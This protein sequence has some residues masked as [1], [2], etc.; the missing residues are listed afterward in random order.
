M[1]GLHGSS[2][3]LSRLASP[4]VLAIFAASLAIGLEFSGGDA[5][6]VAASE[7]WRVAEPMTYEN[8]SVFPVLSRDTADTSGFVTLDEALASGDAVVTEHGAQAMRRSR[9]GTPEF[10]NVPYQEGGARVNQLVLVNHGKRPLVLLAGEVISGGKQD[11]II[12][13]DRIVPVGAEPLPLDVF[14]VEHG[15][16]TTASDK[17][18]AAKMMAHPSV[19]EKAAVSQNQSEVWAAVRSGTTA[20]ARVS[21]G[22]AGASPALTTADLAALERTEA[23]TGSYVKMYGSRR[24]S[25]SVENFAQEVEKRFS[26][27][28]ANLKG[29]RVVGVVVSYGGEVAWSDVFASSQLFDRYWPKLVRSYVVEALARPQLRERASLEDAREFLSRTGGRERIESEPGVYRWV[30][31]T[32]GRYAEIELEALAPKTMTLHWLKVLRTN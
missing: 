18:E 19:R 8:L 15:R 32:E 6:A 12:G 25:G 28:T 30:E 2:V 9:G 23:P 27:A 29:E 11:R 7:N 16:W 17:F 24:V 21:A 3:N 31:R 1:Q 22:S 14:C 20:E 4:A 13:K 10:Q 26:K 5:R